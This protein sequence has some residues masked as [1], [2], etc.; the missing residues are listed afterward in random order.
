M[1][2]LV[3]GEFYLNSLAPRRWGCNLWILIY[4]L[5]SR[6]VILH[7]SCEIDLEWMVQ[8]INDGL[9]TLEQIMA[10]CHQAT[11]I[12]VQVFYLPNRSTWYNLQSASLSCTKVDPVLWHPMALLDIPKSGHLGELWHVFCK[13]KIWCILHQCH[14]WIGCKN[15]VIYIQDCRCKWSMNAS[16]LGV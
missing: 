7:I 15:H 1:V 14:Y 8:D 12:Q 16:S 10:W 6:A 11:S 4:K 5:I 3:H 13:F 9:S 2:L